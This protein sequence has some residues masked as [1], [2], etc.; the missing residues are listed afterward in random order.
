MMTE[1]DPD[2][3]YIIGG[4]VD[5]KDS[6]PLTMAKAKREGIRMAKLPLDK[7]LRWGSSGKSLTLNAMTGRN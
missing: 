2:S 5:K 7:Y 1:F 6:T 4:I 3:V